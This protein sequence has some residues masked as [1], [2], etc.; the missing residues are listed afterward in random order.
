MIRR[1]FLTLAF[2]SLLSALSN[3]AVRTA[4]K[5]DIVATTPD[6]A[7]VVREIGGDRVKVKSIC[8]GK[9][10][11]HAMRPVPSD[12]VALSKADAVVLQGLALEA[13]WLPPLLLNARNRKLEPGKSGYIVV[14]EGWEAIQVPESLSR[15]GGD[16]HPFG[17]PHMNIHPGA[18]RHLAGTILDG[19]SAVDPDSAEL[20]EANHAAY[21]KRLDEAEARWA[22]VAP[23]LKGRKIVVYHQEFDYL[24]WLYGMDQV[25]TIEVKPGIPPTGSHLARVIR[26]MKEDDAELI[27]TAVWSNNKQVRNVSQKTGVQVVELPTMVGGA[28]GADTWIDMM[29]LIHRRLAGAFQ[30][31]EEGG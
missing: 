31:A 6:L 1:T 24:T 23:L 14:S 13:T 7:D 11:V 27:I 28:P 5:L 2:A 21:L 30:P 15:F 12:L 22:E 19:L 10:N 16:L 17:N 26:T 8:R 4:G 29:D 9:E 25:A 20:Y 3:A 18:G